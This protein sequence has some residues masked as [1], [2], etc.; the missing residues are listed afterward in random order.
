M[1]SEK[2]NKLIETIKRA[3]KAALL[4]D[5]EEDGGTCN[6]DTAIIKLDRWREE[7][8]QQV[9]K[10]TGIRIGER[11]SGWHK[12]F[13]FVFTEMYGQANRRTRMAEAAYK[14]LEKDGF[15]VSMY[16]QAD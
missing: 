1:K 9:S 5:N 12:G 14:S 10:E 3:N 16:Y 8:I 4:I 6:F 7:E 11:L 13:R 2:V 15:E